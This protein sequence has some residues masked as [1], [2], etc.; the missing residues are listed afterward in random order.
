MNTIYRVKFVEDVDA[1]FEESNGEPRPLT[2]AEYKGS[3]YQKNGRNVSH[4]EYLLYYGNPE[5]H[6]Y[7]G[8]ILQRQC[9]R[10]EV[11]KTVQSLWNIDCMDDNVEYVRVTLDKWYAPDDPHI[12]GYL[13]DVTKELIAEDVI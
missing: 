10:C 3:E 13:L 2:A 6:V 1:R 5:R 12:T 7:L 9:E 8:C 4:A 11:F